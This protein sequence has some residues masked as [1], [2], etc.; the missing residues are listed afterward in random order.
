[1]SYQQLNTLLVE[2]VEAL[3]KQVLD[4]YPYTVLGKNQNGDW[5][6][7]CAVEN[8]AKADYLADV[9]LTGQGMETKIK[10]TGGN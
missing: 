3:A 2:I 6:F 8:Q 9:L 4:K 10:A 1:L 5:V 7:V